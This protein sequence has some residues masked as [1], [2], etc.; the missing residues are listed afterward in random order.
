MEWCCTICYVSNDVVT[1][2]IM[3]QPLVTKYVAVNYIKNLGLIGTKRGALV[4]SSLESLIASMSKDG[5]VH[6]LSS[7][8]QRK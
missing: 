3:N 8:D 4:V 7:K 1:I 6:V 2:C 5:D